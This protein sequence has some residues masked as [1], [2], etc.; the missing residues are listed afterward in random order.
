MC[1][2]SDYAVGAVLGQRRDKMF[3][4]IYYASCT[5]NTTQQNYK[6]TVK[7]ML[8]VFAF[9]KFR[10][11]LI[12]TKVTVFTDHAAL[13][14]L[15][16]KKEAKPRL[17]RWII[18]LQEFDFEVK[19]KKVVR[20][21]W[22]ITYIANFLAVGELPPDLTHHQ[23]KKFLHDAKFYLWDDPFVFKRCAD[24][25]IKR[26]VAEE[27]AAIATNTNDA[28][29]VVKFVHRN[30]FTRFGTPRAIISDDA[31]GDNDISPASY[32]ASRN[33]QP[34]D[35]EDLRKTVKTNRKD[36][37]IKL[38][39]A[40]WAYRTAYKTP[41]GMS[42]YRLVFGKACHLPFELEYRAFL[43]VKKLNFYMGAAGE[44][45]LLQLNEMEEFRNDAY[46]NAK[47]YKE[48]TKR[49]NDK[50]ILRR[51]FEP[52]QQVLLFN[53]RVRLFPCKLKSRWSR[54]FTVKTLYPHGAI[55]MKCNNGQTF[56]VNGQRVKNYFGSEVR[57][58]DNIPLG[59][60]K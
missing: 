57:N 34:R 52:G 31:H 59:E 19:N 47:I 14:Y 33:I 27:E 43:A 50:E 28:R 46:E 48:K 3:K 55:E 12:G 15:F 20:T 16:A 8:A 42:P 38:D 13:R 60:P 7:E 37:T 10:T 2:A 6:T 1:N 32:W 29:V 51:D 58:M 21:K 49:W 17:I 44:Q 36:W 23:K 4:A 56:K 26:C 41:I 54:P 35:Q 45:R 24:Q 22:Q 11:Y 5:L 25:I 18:R 39:D 40:L 53:S 9:D 30:I